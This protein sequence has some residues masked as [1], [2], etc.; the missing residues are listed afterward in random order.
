MSLDLLS[1][2]S[3]ARQP[4]TGF[5]LLSWNLLADCHIR[6]SWYPHVHPAHLDNGWRHPRLI[7]RLLELEADV[8]AL[9]EVDPRLLPALSRA[10]PEHHLTHAP[11]G[12]EGMVLLVRGGAE[13]VERLVLP[14]GRKAALVADLPGGCR[15]ASVHLS[16]TGPP[17]VAQRRRGLEQ[18]ERVLERRPHLLCGDLNALPG[19]PERRRLEE[20]GLVDRSPVGAT[21]NMNQWLQALDGVYATPGWTVE[22][23]ALPVIGE[24]TPMPSERCPSDHLPV[25]VSAST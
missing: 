17:E 9:Q 23:E 6:P 5:T 12:G 24:C 16:W 22:A 11:Y 19:W 13:R 15:L 20:A 21:C 3:E 7:Q 4:W 14:G 18:L 8:M 1:W 10:F 25:R 2:R